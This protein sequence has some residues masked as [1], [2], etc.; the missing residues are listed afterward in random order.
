MIGL[1]RQQVQF[2]IK[3]FVQFMGKGRKER[4]V[5]LWPTTARALKAWFKEME[6]DQRNGAIAFPN[7]RGRA[8][9]R[10]G[11]NYLLR[12]CVERAVANCPSLTDKRIS[13]HVFRHS[14]AMHLLQAGVDITVIAL[15]LGPRKHSDKARIHRSGYGHQRASSRKSRASRAARETIQGRRRATAVPGNALIM[16]TR[17]R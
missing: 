1:R 5:P 12:E 15:C 17:L 14:A 2:G 7:A 11:V 13:P 6:S 8:L 10:D 9:S 4:A 16:P 3:S